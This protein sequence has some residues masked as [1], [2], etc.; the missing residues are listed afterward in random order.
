MAMGCDT[1]VAQPNTITGS[2]GI[3]GMMFDMSGF[4]GNKIGITF[5]EV[6]TGN[7]GDMYTVS[8]PL[9]ETERNYWQKNLDEHYDTFITKAAEG[10]GMA[11]EEIAKVASGRV[12]T[13]N[14]AL[15]NKLVD[16][17]GG[18]D[19]A[20]R[21]AAEKAHLGDDYRV[22]YFPKQKSFFEA[23]IEEKEEVATEAALKNEL[24]EYYRFY[25]QLKKLKTYQGAQARMP[26][27]I[28]ME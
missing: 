9:T 7:F 10:R 16:V 4:L 15:G 25:N 11:K 2:I 14:Q 3:F 20:I 13:G 1:I 23:W 27:E 6:R 17:E 8:R 19:D 21:I 22:K 12:W 5:D 24:G 28:K 26:F 18:F